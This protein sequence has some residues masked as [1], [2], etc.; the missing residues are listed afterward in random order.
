MK[1]AIS[2]NDNCIMMN[3]LYIMIFPSRLGELRTVTA[4]DETPA[5]RSTE[6]WVL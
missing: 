6:G 2:Y 5:L 4:H 3:V 1:S